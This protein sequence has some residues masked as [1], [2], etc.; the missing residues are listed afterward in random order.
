MTIELPCEV[1]DTVYCIENNEIITRKVICFLIGQL[2]P[3]ASLENR[4]VK[5]KTFDASF[6]MFGKTV[7]LSRTEAQRSYILNQL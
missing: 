6:D 4:K 3:I 5:I 2:S 7:F 1:N